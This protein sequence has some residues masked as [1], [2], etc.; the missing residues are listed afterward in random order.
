MAPFAFFVAALAAGVSSAAPSSVKRQGY[1]CPDQCG[2]NDCV[3]YVTQ[4]LNSISASLYS[5]IGDR[6]SCDFSQVEPCLGRVVS[7]CQWVESVRVK[8]DVAIDA[9]ANA[10]VRCYS[11]IAAILQQ[12]IRVISDANSYSSYFDRI[13]NSCTSWL[14]YI[15]TSVYNNIHVY[16]GNLIRG[17]NELTEGIRS[18]GFSGLNEFLGIGLSIL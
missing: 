11:R 10:W 4:E 9:F 7:L 13:D 15:N 2:A 12:I 16:V 6:Q 1:Q 18:C 5:V 14:H 8:V 17:D 3:D